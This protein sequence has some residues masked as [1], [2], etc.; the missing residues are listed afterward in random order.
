MEGDPATLTIRCDDEDCGKKLML[1]DSA[2]TTMLVTA[3]AR[4]PK[5][6]CDAKSVG[7]RC[8]A[9]LRTLNRSGFERISPLTERPIV[10]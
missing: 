4:P 9:A 10:H 8:I 5:W 2:A 7:R 1:S 3:V 6:M